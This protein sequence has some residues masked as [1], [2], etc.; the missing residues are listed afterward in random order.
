MMLSRPKMSRMLRASHLE[1]SEMNISSVCKSRPAA[2]LVL[3][4]GIA[5][6]VVPCSGP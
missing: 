2:E 1:P 3:D 5:E 6:E 4:D